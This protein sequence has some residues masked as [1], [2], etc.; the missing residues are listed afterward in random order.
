M[1]LHSIIEQF[2][3]LMDAP[4]SVSKLRQFILKLAVQGKLTEQD[5][6]DEPADQLL[7]KSKEEKKR[8]RKANS[9]RT[10]SGV[11][12]IEKSDEP[13]SLPDGWVWARVANVAS[14]RGGKR[15]PKGHSL[16]KNPTDQIY[17]RVTDMED[18]S[19]SDAD[20]HYLEEDTARGISKYII[21]KQDLYI[22][23]AGTIGEVGEVPE[24]FD[25]MNL[26]ENAARITPH[27]IS[28]NYLLKVLN[29][30]PVQDQFAEYVNQMAQ[31]KLALRRI[32]QTL[33]PLPPL[34]EQQRIVATADRLMDECDTLEAQQDAATEVRVR[35]TEAAT[36]ALQTADTPAAVRTAWHRLR[37]HFATLTATPD[38]V[39]AVR[40]TILQLA[41]QG[42]LTEQYPNDEPAEVLLE[43]I[44]AE[45]QRLYEAGEIRK[46]KTFESPKPEDVPFSLPT[47]WTWTRLGIPFNIVRGITFKKADKKRE[48]EEG[49]IACLRTANIQEEVEWEDLIYV[50]SEKV[51]RDEQW[52]RKGDTII[53]M[54]NSYELVGKVAYVKEV[55]LKSSFGGFLGAVRPYHG[56]DFKYLYLSLNSPLL[57]DSMRGTSNQTTNIANLSLKNIT[58]LPYPLPPRE[59]QQRIVATVDRLMEQCDVLEAQLEQEQTLGGE[60]LEAV[61]HGA[62]QGEKQP[63]MQEAMT[64]G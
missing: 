5:P 37:D 8:F 28:K 22:T 24:R 17:I 3:V 13:R 29:S 57:Q 27:L 7:A 35:C 54:S 41:V 21:K 2:D 6:N 10:R 44:Q 18:G 1:T 14:I 36:H 20:L 63:A 15:V 53:S 40:Q 45:K 52:V 19:I 16:T 56:V 38:A 42:K 64:V 46:P 61:L 33:I 62:A 9:V 58:P 12:A 47:G 11:P 51:N 32:R 59:E 30:A 48:P 26:T 39:D 25:G 50:D 23:I 49:T 60:L 31:P 4:D 43:R 55:P 34:E